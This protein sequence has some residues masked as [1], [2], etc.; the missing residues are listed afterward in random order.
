MAKR[1]QSEEQAV[2]PIAEISKDP[3]L[4]QAVE[5]A[6]HTLVILE[7]I[8]ISTTEQYELAGEHLKSIKA[9]MKRVKEIKTRIKAPIIEAG[10]QVDALFD[11]P[12]KNLERSE[13]ALKVAM[14]GYQ[15]ELERRRREQEAKLQE[16]QRRERDRLARRAEQAAA[17]GNVDKAEE[18]RQQADMTTAPVIANPVPGIKGISRSTTWK[19]EVT[20]LMALA[21]AVVAGEVPANVIM[22]DM[23]VLGQQAR[24]LGEAMRYPGV[25]VYEEAVLAATAG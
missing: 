4:R 24:A 5:D 20:D 18:L 15:D 16:Q 8:K 19:A 25:R 14:I 3:E 21:R 10:K 7:D 17:K 2:K 13:R 1:K 23:R 12:L 22:A 9:Q 11:A 6:E